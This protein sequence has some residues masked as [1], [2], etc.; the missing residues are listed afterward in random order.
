MLPANP[1]FGGSVAYEQADGYGLATAHVAGRHV[2]GRRM[3]TG[4]QPAPPQT[5]PSGGSARARLITGRVRTAAGSRHCQT[6]APRAGRQGLLIPDDRF[7]KVR[8]I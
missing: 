3:V 1:R 4:G 7:D 5:R 8:A 6:P 2:H